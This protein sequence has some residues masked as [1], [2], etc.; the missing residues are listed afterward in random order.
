MSRFPERHII[1]VG[2]GASGVLLAYQLL[3]RPESDVRVTLI[4]K[5]SEVGRGLAYHT[6]NADH[7]L[8]VRAANM[9]ALP[10]DPDHFWRW[11][12]THEHGLQLCPDPF[13]FV[14]RRLYG[15]YIASLIAPHLAAE[16]GARRL[17]IIQGECVAV[18]EGRDGVTVSLADGTRQLGEVAVFAT[19]HDAAIPR[20]AW[21]ADPW[22]NPSVPGFSRD[23]AVLILGA[24]LTMADYVL[25]L[26]REGHRGP[27]LAISRRGLMA[28]GHRRISPC[29]ISEDE[30]PF[31]ARGSVLLRWFRERI[32]A[33]VAEGGDWRAVIDAVRPFS[34]RLWQD[35]PLASKRSFLEHARAWWDVHRHRMAPEVEARITKAIE[36]RQLRIAAAKLVKIDGGT[37]GARAHYRRRGRSEI[38]TLE[39]GAVIDCTGIVKDPRATANPAVRSL[40][41]Q[42]LARCDPLRIGIEVTADCAI[43]GADG[44]PSQR[45]FAIGP[46]TR[47][48]FWEIIAIPDIRSQC[49]D[50][51][52]RLLQARQITVPKV[53]APALAAARDHQVAM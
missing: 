14:P 45:L 11:L 28:K 7:L 10:D 23:S 31:G 9:S 38:E 18:S 17:A 50:L 4:E 34:H 8:N 42:G 27:I 15:D 40:F 33:H 39:V 49:A 41:D 35:L 52:G 30:V 37:Q 48:A 13:C 26:L 44:T 3:Q 22:I 51:A 20:S 53:D 12:S 24:G 16:N 6:G 19:G 5:R 21:H 32:K 43:V 46:L 47:A 2:G 36:D 1:I 25:S 29:R